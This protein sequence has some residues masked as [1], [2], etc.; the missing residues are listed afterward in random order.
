MK[1]EEK[2]H[3]E[4]SRFYYTVKNSRT[5]NNNPLQKPPIF[6]LNIIEKLI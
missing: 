6:V 3:L 2:I 5:N 1:K 4:I